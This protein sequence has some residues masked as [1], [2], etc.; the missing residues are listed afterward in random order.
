MDRMYEVG[1]SITIRHQLDENVARWNR[2]AWQCI[3]CGMAYHRQRRTIVPSRHLCSRCRGG[4]VEVT[5]EQSPI[6]HPGMP[7]EP[8]V[9]EQITG[10]LPLGQ[11]HFDF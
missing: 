9:E 10:P 5:L 1:L 7:T 11:L 2:Y 4:L 3:R 8:C 6:A